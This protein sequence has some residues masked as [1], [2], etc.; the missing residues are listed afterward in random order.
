MSKPDVALI[1]LG[2]MGFPM[3]R[4]IAEAGFALGVFDI[5]EANV[6]RFCTAHS[7]TPVHRLADAAQAEIVI[8]ILPTSKEV[9]EV[10]T[11]VGGLAERMRPGT[12][13]VDCSPRPP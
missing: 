13:L 1:G 5:E 7:T 6:H 10:V 4:H 3:A 11:A 8:T 12:I 2:R 9:G